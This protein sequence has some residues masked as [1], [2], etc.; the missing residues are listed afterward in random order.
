[1]ERQGQ[2]LF[3]GALCDGAIGGGSSSVAGNT[4]AGNR[5][6]R[7]LPG[8][9]KGIVNQCLDPL[10]SQMGLQR[11]AFARSDHE[12]MVN[13]PIVTLRQRPLPSTSLGMTPA[14]G[15]ACEQPAICISKR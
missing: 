7:R 14:L 3:S 2:N 5:R 10:C 8:Q 6:E 4:H 15:A 13:M 12:E 11:V 9:R 1:M